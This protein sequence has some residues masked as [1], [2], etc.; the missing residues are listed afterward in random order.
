[1]KKAGSYVQQLPS[2][3]ERGDAKDDLVHNVMIKVIQ[4]QNTAKGL[5]E[6]VI[7]SCVF[8]YINMSTTRPP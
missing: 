1:M 7:I 6:S 8:S 5:I 4:E 3:Q 2:S